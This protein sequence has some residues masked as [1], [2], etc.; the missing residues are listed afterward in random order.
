MK[1]DLNFFPS[2]QSSQRS[3]SQRK[4]GNREA[5][6]AGLVGRAG[7]VKVQMG[8][9]DRGW[10]QLAQEKLQGQELGVAVLW[11]LKGG[12]EGRTGLEWTILTQALSYSRTFQ[13]EHIPDFW[14]RSQNVIFPRQTTL[15]NCQF[16]THRPEGQCNVGESLSSASDHPVCWPQP[17]A[18]LLLA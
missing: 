12:R 8:R 10:V 11:G 9:P 16:R 4:N 18:D 2:L 14:G 6:G 17:P 5:E 1:T 15:S 7:L 13:G 3:I